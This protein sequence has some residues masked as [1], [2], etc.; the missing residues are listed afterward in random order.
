MF[1]ID[2]ILGD[3]L[4]YNCLSTDSF[5]GALPFLSK[6]INRFRLKINYRLYYSLITDTTDIPNHITNKQK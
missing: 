1:V 3:S 5:A 6:Q 4:A 2:L